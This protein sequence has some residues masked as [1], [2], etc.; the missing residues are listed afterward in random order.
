MWKI[1]TEP[2]VSVEKIC[3]ECGKV[4]ETFSATH[5]L[6]QYMIFDLQA[7]IPDKVNLDTLDFGLQPYHWCPIKPNGSPCLVPLQTTLR[8]TQQEKDA[9]DERR[10]KTIITTNLGHATY[11][12]TKK[13][14]SPAHKGRPPKTVLK[15]IEE[16]K[17]DSTNS[18]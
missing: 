5:P 13:S 15:V 4:I 3:N 2:E 11:K 8:E 9:T 1:I 17:D 14:D 10:L 16:L 6:T 7:H 18:V 12:P